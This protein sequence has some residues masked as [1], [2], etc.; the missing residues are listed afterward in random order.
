[1][2]YKDIWNDLC[3][4]VSQKSRSASEHDF[5]II[6][7]SSFEKL[8]WSQHKGEIIAQKAISVGASNNVKPDIVIKKDGGTL[9]VVELKK[10]NSTMSD[11]NVEQLFSYMR[12]LKLNFGI[13]IGETLRAYYE[14]PNDNKLSVQI[15]DI[16]FKNDSEEG[17]GI[18]KL[19]SK[20]EYSFEEFKKYCEK[21]LAIRE[22]DE[23]T[24]RYIHLLCSEEGT[25]IIM[26]LL[27]A[28]LSTDY[29]EEVAVSIINEITISILKKGENGG[30]ILF[31]L[32]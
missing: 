28:K 3:F 18:I 13:L 20:N 27:K 10:P 5:Q 15:C 24:Q 11:R 14:L 7:E 9:F 19:L 16:I 1:M 23:T 29:S 4:H 26:D 17:I 22:K 31:C 32:R 30:E 21:K 6:A 8:G 2:E 12:L 25:D